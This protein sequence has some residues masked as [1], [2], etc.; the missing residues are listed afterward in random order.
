MENAPVLMSSLSKAAAAFAESVCEVNVDQPMV[1]KP[2]RPPKL[3][4]L[5]C[6]VPRQ[7]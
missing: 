6:C 7:T 4:K 3:L 2:W 5:E 1:L